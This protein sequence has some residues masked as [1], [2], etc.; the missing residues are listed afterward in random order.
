MRLESAERALI[1]LGGA[2]DRPFR[3]EGSYPHVVIALM[4]RARSLFRGFV[5]SFEGPAPIAALVL[6]R[7]LVEINILLRFLGQLP[8][9]RAHSWIAERFR[10]SLAFVEA[11][12]QHENLR[13]KFVAEFPSPAQLAGWRDVVSEARQLASAS[14][15]PSVG[16]RGP[17]I[18]STSRQVQLLN[19]DAATEAYVFA[20]RRFSGDVHGGLISFDL[21]HVDE[22][23]DD[24]VSLSEEVS[25]DDLRSTRVLGLT[26]Y[27]STLRVG[28]ESMGLGITEAAD[29]VRLEFMKNVE[30]G[31]QSGG[32]E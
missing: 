17:L 24:V 19:D 22:R 14:N 25:A 27:A 32:T 21:L 7:P 18:P 9:V 30:T 20:Y 6:L 13:E 8:E 4:Q 11:V 3:A 2:F 16:P 10:W 28:S 12:A 29:A 5:H 15:D 1:E 26:T 23:G 31:S